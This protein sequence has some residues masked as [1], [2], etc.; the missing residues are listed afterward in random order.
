[1]HT[2][3][4]ART[5]QCGFTLAELMVAA[6]LMSLVGLI[7][8][9]TVIGGM[10][11]AGRGE[12]RTDDAA[13]AQRALLQISAD[14]RASDGFL[15]ASGSSLVVHTRTTLPATGS[16]SDDPERVTYERTTA[17]DLVQTRQPVTRTPTA[18]D[19]WTAV[20]TPTT[21]TVLKGVLAPAAA[22]RPLFTYLSLQDSQK[23]CATGATASTL[24]DPV[25]TA[26]LPD[27]YSVDIWLSVN[28]AAHLGGTPLVVPGGVV[29]ANRGA[30]RLDA[31]SSS[32]GI[33]SGT[34]VCA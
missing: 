26:D 17:G 33:G 34:G 19:T 21:T 11:T 31:P 8:V 13:A 20:G 2:R 28:S 14:L 5:D 27:I 15:N 6:V 16:P 12:K 25:A 22:G 3:R 30:L 32:L 29:V 1:M 7:V 24:G 18:P 4:P 10:R 9:T 23:Q